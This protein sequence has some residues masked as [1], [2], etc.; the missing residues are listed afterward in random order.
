MLV[1]LI[2]RSRSLLSS[3]LSAAASYC[4]SMF[5]MRLTGS[6]SVCLCLSAAVEVG[7]G[8]EGAAVLGLPKAIM[9]G[10]T[11]VF[12]PWVA[13]REDSGIETGA[14]VVVIRVL[15]TAS[16]VGGSGWMGMLLPGWIHPVWGGGGYRFSPV[17]MGDRPPSEKPM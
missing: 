8:I 13:L 11:V 9:D 10:V 3:L 2:S 4:R 6:K 17:E 15:E 12:I 7:I 16:L 1:T 14:V 5:S